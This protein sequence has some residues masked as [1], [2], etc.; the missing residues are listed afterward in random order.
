MKKTKQ[1][2]AVLLSLVM[3][4]VLAIPASAADTYSITIQNNK[5]GH[6]YE[7]YQIFAGDVSSDAQQ[8]GIVDGPILSNITWGNG[9]NG[10]TL[11]AALKEADVAKYGACETAAEVAKALGAENATAEHAAAFAEIAALHLTNVAGTANEP[12][13]GN[14][15]INNLA[16]G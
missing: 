8:E 6:T 9:V 13:E 4:L 7:A 10:T 12:V 14:Y 1:L 5:T 3:L 2:A 16:A 15:V 11:L